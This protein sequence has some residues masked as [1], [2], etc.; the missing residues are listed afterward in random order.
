MLVAEMH[1]AHSY[2]LKFAQILHHDISPGNISRTD[3][4]KGLLIDWELAKDINEVGSERPDRTVSISLVVFSC[5]LM[6]KI[7]RGHSCSCLLT[8]L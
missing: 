2:A 7:V 6:K 8:Y 5:S 1:E 3:N 4:G